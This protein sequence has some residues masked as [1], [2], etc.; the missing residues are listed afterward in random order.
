MSSN[1][2]IQPNKRLIFVGK[3]R[4]GKTFLA[5]QLLRMILDRTK[6]TQV[7][8]IDPKHETTFFGNGEDLEHP[9]L[10]EKYNS[11]VR[12]Q[13]FQTFTWNEHLEHMVDAVLKRGNAIVVL[14]EIGGIA[15]AT[16]VPT[17]ITRLWTQGG[18]KN[19]GAWSLVQFPR[20][21]PSV[22]KTQSEHWFIFR[23]NSLDERKELLN[24]IP[25]SSIL[26]KLEKYYFKYF[27]DDMDT[28]TLFS[29]IKTITKTK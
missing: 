13:V 10:V 18:G 20:R 23:L 29:P 22:I 16:T 2:K 6:D 3:T 27:N 24:F 9:K 26:E 12:V 28:C 8:F 1:L 5:K 4:S 21:I 15:T 19:V 7:I 14:D 17:G 11:K 25:D